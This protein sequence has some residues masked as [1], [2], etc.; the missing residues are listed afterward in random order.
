MI[1]EGEM[2]NTAE[3]SRPA[4]AETATEGEKILS[5]NCQAATMVV[6]FQVTRIAS[7]RTA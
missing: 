1:K 2:E 7:V 6:N 5:A 4:G 3:E